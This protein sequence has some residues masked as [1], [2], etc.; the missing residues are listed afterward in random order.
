MVRH[1]EKYY[2]PLRESLASALPLVDEFVLALGRGEPGEQTEAWVSA[3]EDPKLRVFMRDWDEAKFRDSLIFKEETDF[4]MQQCQGVWGLYLQADEVLHEGDYERIRQACERYREDLEVE[5]LLFDYHHF[6]GD[7]EHEL[8]SHAWYRQEIRLVRLGVGVESYKDAQSFRCQGRRLKV[9]H[10]GAKIYHY[11]WVRPPALMQRKKRAHDAMHQGEAKA[12]ELYKDRQGDFDYGPM[13][14]IP[15]FKGSHPAVMK[16]RMAELSW[17][18]TLN[19]AK[20]GPARHYIKHERLK[21]RFL[22]WIEN[23]LLGGRT[24]FGFK[25]WQ[26]IR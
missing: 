10:S 9:G 12:E 20:R 21:Y 22:S 16:A 6:W 24:L 7:Y 3:I 25:N 18:E 13:G 17:R 11:G 1:A 4:A 5:G 8:R 2:F 26:R 15:R 14:R 19:P 23:N